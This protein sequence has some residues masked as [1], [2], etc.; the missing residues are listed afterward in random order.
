MDKALECST[1]IPLLHRK[2]F[3]HKRTR[4][5]QSQGP[6]GPNGARKPHKPCRLSALMQPQRFPNYPPSNPTR[7]RIDRTN[8]AHCLLSGI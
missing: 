5:L 7:H 1:K 6:R 2:T 8:L 4:Q 3:I